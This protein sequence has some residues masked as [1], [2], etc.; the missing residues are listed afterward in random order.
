MEN[1]TPEIFAEFQRTQAEAFKKLQLK[2]ESKPQDL[3][4]LAADFITMAK[5]MLKKQEEKCD[6]IAAME[7][8]IKELQERVTKLENEKK[9]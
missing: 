1:L 5:D 6:K 8:E 2:K 7:K 9:T 3:P 4:T